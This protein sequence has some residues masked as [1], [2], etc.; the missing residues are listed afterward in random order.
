MSP[1][2][3]MGSAMKAVARL[4]LVAGIAFL[5]A[6]ARRMM[7]VCLSSSGRALWCCRGGGAGTRLCYVGANRKPSGARGDR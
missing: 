2:L 7:K 6:A 3:M 5:R 1:A 4:K